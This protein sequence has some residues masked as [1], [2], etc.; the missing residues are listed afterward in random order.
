MRIFISFSNDESV[1]LQAFTLS[2]LRDTRAQAK[3][4]ILQELRRRGLLTK[5]EP[6]KGVKHVTA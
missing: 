1:A 3:L 5:E 2:Q 6:K 4:L